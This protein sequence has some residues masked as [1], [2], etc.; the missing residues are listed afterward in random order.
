ME[1]LY[2]SPFLV[3]DIKNPLE[4]KK[5]WSEILE[6]IS[7]PS[8]ILFERIRLK[9]PEALSPREKKSV[10]R[11]LL[12][13]KYRAT[14]FGRW[15]GVGV[16]KW[17]PPNQF[18]EE[19]NT[20]TTVP[21][22]FR[23]IPLDSSEYWLNPSLERWGNGWKFWNFDSANQQWRYSKSADSPLIQELRHQSFSGQPIN[24]DR[25]FGAFPSL[26]H[27]E[28]EAIWNRLTE[29][30]L[31]T[32]S[33]V[34]GVTFP[35]KKEDHFIMDKPAL[36]NHHKQKLDTFFAEIGN[37]AVS[38]H[39]VYLERLIGRFEEEFDD[40]FVP[41]KMLWK[42]VPYLTQ[43]SREV[44]STSDSR[45]PYLPSLTKTDRLDLRKL[46]INTGNSRKIRH[47]QAL[48]RI[49]GNGRILLDNLVFNRPFVY[50]GRFTKQPEIFQYFN[51]LPSQEEGVVYAD[52][53]LAEGQKAQHISSHRSITPYT[54]NCL[55]GSTHPYELDTRETYI[56]IHEGKFILMTPKF[57]KQVIPL[58]QHPLNPQYIT[59]PLCRILW[60]VAHQDFLR[61]LYYSQGQF[62]ASEYLPQLEWG[63]I[64]LQ[65]RQ[66]RIKWNDRYRK[67]KDFMDHIAGLGIPTK[68][69][70]GYQ[71]QEL[72]LDLD[73]KEDRF[74]LR[75]E[76]RQNK[77]IHIQEWLWKRDSEHTGN[78]KC[79]YPQFLWGQV[80]KNTDQDFY[81]TESI[82]YISEYES[83]EW[84]SARI[85][86]CP[87]F[88]IPIIQGQ[89][90]LYFD[91]LE[92]EG[93]RP[94]YFLFYRLKKAEI[95]VRCRI[96]NQKEKAKVVTLLHAI[97]E[98]I[99]DIDHIK[100]TPYYPE[101]AKYSKQAMH[102][103]EEIFY[104]ESKIILQVNPKSAEEKIRLAV[105]IGSI[106]LAQEED[107]EFSI[108]VMKN[109]SGRRVSHQSAKNHLALFE[110]A[111][112]EEWRAYY[113]SLVNRHPWTKN[114][115]KKG[116]F[117][118]N[119]LHMLINRIFWDKALEMEPEIYAL[120]GSIARE[121]KYGK[122]KK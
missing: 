80:N 77:P 52:V 15:A 103:S 64:I 115:K 14:P 104:Q 91:R 4:I 47:T 116:M 90:T 68:V 32:S 93:I 34:P 51:C 16:A 55:T 75:E 87:D 28:R 11:Y 83:N 24:K 45:A 50:G 46:A 53:I 71:D 84:V 118:A 48:F 58:F 63:D 82:N 23:E 101:Y 26:L 107:P 13:G 38:Q 22:Q 20:L 74:I 121:K 56:G 10:Y 79:Y 39:N 88:Q 27:A 44:K 49:L 108:E 6:A 8:P 54:L 72:A 94:Y 18:T 57:G 35:K 70:V 102:V 43:E 98:N 120:L 73:C 89:L 12:R 114:Q 30:Q 113:L 9:Q 59:H 1:L 21:I 78:N 33:T 31:L 86:L 66:W 3:F 61:P 95:R 36:S 76:L 112:A 40:R 119:H 29:Q 25:L 99:P 81:P 7:L 97:Q 85:I 96:G 117:I 109:L 67:E 110:K 122:P 69:M 5:H 105:G 111:T 60:E 19:G 37:L 41:L 65:P 92:Q 17:V 42:L 62:T 100:I 106:Y 2:R